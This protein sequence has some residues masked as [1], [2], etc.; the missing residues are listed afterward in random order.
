[1][2]GLAPEH[3]ADLRRSGLTDLTIERAGVYSIPPHELRRFPGI[4]SGLAFPYPNLDGTVNGLRR[5]K[6]FPPTKD[7]DGHTIRY[8]QPA[9]TDPAVYFPSL[10]DWRAI[11]SDPSRP[12]T[13]TEGE[14]KALSLMQLGLP[15]IGL[16]GLWSF[17]TKADGMRML[18]PALDRIAWQDRSVE[19]APDSDV[20]AR[21]ELLNAVVLLAL[22]LTQRGA[23]VQIVRL[24]DKGGLKQGAD[25]FLVSEA[26]WPRQAWEQLERL[27]L[28]D[29]RL[30][31]AM[32][33]STR[34]EEKER[35]H[36][37][38]R[39]HDVDALDLNETA[40]FYT[41]TSG[42]YG[43]RISFD[44]LTDHRGVTAEVTVSLG[45]TELLAGVDLGLKSD[46]GQTKLAQSLKTFSSTVPWKLLL[47]RA[48]ALVVRHYRT[49]DPL[50]V[51]D[52]DTAV[53]PLTYQ[54]NPLCYPGK[55][56]IV[57][58][59]GGL[60][61]STLGLLLA[62]CVSTGEAVAGF[63]A[64]PGETLYLDYEDSADVHARRLQAIQ[65]GHPELS[66]AS[67]LYQ[68]AVEPLT[69]IVHPVIRQIRANAITFMVLDS[70]LAATGGD[71]S[72]EGTAKL[73]AALRT[74]N[75][76]VLVIA[77]VP[78]TQ[79]EGQDHPTVYGS[80][81]NQNFARAVWE[82]KKEQETGE[83]MLTLG[84]FNRKSNL[85]RI[86]PPIGLHV[87]QAPDGSRIRFEPADLSKVAELAASLPLP[88]KIRNLL[89]SDGIP[90][91]AQE[92]ADTLGAN[93]GS[94]KNTLSRHNRLKW[95]ML[96]EN[97]DAKWTVLSR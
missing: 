46:S 65:A 5:I 59:D 24:P 21:D 53:E 51:L 45:T 70:L 84:L 69:K 50:I 41:V 26:A 43:V 7:K 88:N 2:T 82:L 90:R 40:G 95:H 72:A 30:K 4:T 11:A 25:D 47:Q 48:C 81:F 61:K 78:K 12:L 68:R 13:I 85:S 15:A 33:W 39:Q 64:L 96:G 62:M 74:L 94:V 37:S 35:T 27:S 16:G 44:R 31:K 76:T 75:V 79:G 8:A 80:V 83:D 71:A 10:T 38:L 19:L 73:F 49:G 23:R 77:H 29:P 67:V 92:I 54:I 9:G 34:W 17:L 42:K 56:T 63:R 28:D 87:T 32:A 36:E 52:K 6:L 57:Y 20:W 18:L 86:H 66:G 60:G 97:K 93:L 3:L 89:E 14:K 55:I 91:S 58:A 22:S 1:M